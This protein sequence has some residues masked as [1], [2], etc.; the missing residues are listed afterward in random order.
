MV[1]FG[2]AL[3]PRGDELLAFLKRLSMPNATVDENFWEVEW[4]VED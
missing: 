3:M 4:L 1:K 2:Q